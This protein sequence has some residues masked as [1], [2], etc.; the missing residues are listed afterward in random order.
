MGNMFLWNGRYK[1]LGRCSIILL[2][3]STSVLADSKTDTPSPIFGDANGTN[4]GRYRSIKFTNGTTT[5]NG[6]G[7]ITISTGGGSS[8]PAGASGAVQYNNAGVAGGDVTN[9]S[10]NGA[11]V[12]VGTSNPSA[13]LN[14]V[15]G[16]NSS[17]QVT[18]QA[19]FPPYTG[20]T[21]WSRNT[22]STLDKEIQFKG[23]SIY[24]S[25]TGT[26]DA[27]FYVNANGAGDQIRINGT[28]HNVGIGGPAVIGSSL[29]V[30]G[31]MAIGGSGGTP[32]SGLS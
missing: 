28:S 24:F 14:V 9:L 23:S 18:S 21:F 1:I 4:A 31:N 27:A 6:D 12:G 29:S 7:S 3:I 8:T 15:N 5:N 20:S 30:Q 10:F 11:N 17:L 25:P 16:T 32:Y 22:S 13:K 19:D 26:G 2:F